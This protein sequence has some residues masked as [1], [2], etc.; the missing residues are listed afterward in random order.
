MTSMMMKRAA[1]L[2]LLMFALL[3]MTACSGE[4]TVF[5]SSEAFT[6]YADRVEQEGFQAAALG[7]ERLVSDY[8]SPEAGKVHSVIE[9]K[10]SMNG[11]DNEMGFGINHQANIYP[12]EEDLVILETVFGQ[13]ARLRDTIPDHLALPEETR[14]LFRLDLREVLA[15]FNRQGWYEDVH[16]NQIFREDFQGV[17]IA[18][19]THPLSWDFENLAGNPDALMVDVNSDGIYEKELVFHVP[20]P[21]NQL[22]SEWILQNDLSSY[23]VFTAESPLLE[24]IYNMALDEMVMLIEDDGTF[25]TGA[26]W[27][28]VWT[29][30]I[31]YSVL[32]S[33]A[34]LEPQVSKNS[35]WRKVKNGRIIQDTGTGGAYPV[36][37]D[38][39]VWA[40]AAWE[41]YKYTG[42]REWLEQAYQV[43]SNSLLD[44]GKNVYNQDHGLY[45]GES[46]FLDW[47][48]QTY[49]AW[50]EPSD[51]F[52]S[53]N[54]G[55]NAV[56]YQALH[57][58]GLMA[59]EL[60]EDGLP[61]LEKAEALKGRINDLFWLEEKGHY[62]QYLYGSHYKTLSPRA[63]TLGEALTVLFDIAGPERKD[64]ILENTPSLPFGVPCIFPQIP[65]IPP[66]HNNGIWP[67]VQAYWVWAAASRGHAPIVTY[68]WAGLL[69]Q[70]ALF[71]TNKENFVAETGDYAGTEVNSDRQ[72]W[73]VAGQLAMNYR[74]LFG[75][76]F[77]VDKM[78]FSPM[79]P[80]SFEGHYQ[81]KNFSYRG[82]VYNIS[83]SGY[84]NGIASFKVDGR[85]TEYHHVP[86]GLEGLIHI[87][88]TMN[89]KESGGDFNL[90][91]NHTAP[92][93]P[94]LRLTESGLAWNNV[95]GAVSY[96]VY[97][98]GEPLGSQTETTSSLHGVSMLEEY[99]VLAVDDS[100]V[101]S[102]LSNPVIHTSGE[103]VRLIQAEDFNLAAA[104]S[105][106]GYSGQGYV[107][108]TRQNN[109]R[110]VF[111]AEIPEDGL[112]SFVFRYANGSGPVNTE[113]KCAIRSMFVNGDF[114]SALA[115][116]QRGSLEWSN[117]GHTAPVL[118]PL[119][120]GR[121]SFEIRL[122]PFNEN[123]NMVVND[124]LL[125]RIMISRVR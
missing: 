42:D 60:S 50:M 108:F 64:L 121:N 47:R 92:D 124:F 119:K 87:E 90:R 111:D 33:L 122:E 59:N 69:R 37:S 97:R 123:M 29:R 61:W 125:D 71:L 94:V 6:V 83:V 4:E 58:L 89:G 7:G 24:A 56:F 84:G 93:T 88:I 18:G 65:N 41:I 3:F 78:T 25:R 112:Y 44:D 68:G 11:R 34:F 86:A 43:I 32:L 95:P 76:G 73:S 103:S 30:D 106:D 107:V 115:F 15:A 105:F 40:L 23:P 51:I 102:F 70:A 38:R 100:G 99:Q 63:E 72:Q 101:P 14:V 116:P 98:N 67:F 16:G 57:I 48:R 9:F 114:A 53:M 17:F 2:P 10:F 8:V 46:S 55:T 120:S 19:S 27:E 117:W 113:N 79:I 54:L 104:R 109:A 26:E 91:E 21:D 20:D 35:L 39:V 75:I 118:Y 85:E 1:L 66:Y 96:T 74:I 45:Q 28:G 5:Y 12:G 82:G 77:D 110:L 81:L 22:S 80:K 49:P 36:S 13:Q 62:G 31:S 52:V